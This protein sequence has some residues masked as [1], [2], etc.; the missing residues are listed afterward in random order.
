MGKFKGWKEGDNNLVDD[1][2]V[3]IGWTQG[4]AELG[5]RAST[6]GVNLSGNGVLWSKAIPDDALLIS[7]ALWLK[8]NGHAPGL[9]R[10][11]DYVQEMKPRTLKE[12]R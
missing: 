12:G 10:L 9:Q 3:R 6:S 4:D 7:F 5:M 2:F 1:N 8:R 11:D